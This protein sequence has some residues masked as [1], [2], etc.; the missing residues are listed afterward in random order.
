M[1]TPQE[2]KQAKR[3]LAR[4]LAAGFTIAGA[5]LYTTS[6]PNTGGFSLSRVAIAFGVGLVCALFGYGVGTLI[7]RVRG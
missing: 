5:G 6:F 4:R 1:N 2:P 3:S 7:D